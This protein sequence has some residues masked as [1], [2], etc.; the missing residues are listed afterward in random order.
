MIANAGAF[1]TKAVGFFLLV[2]SDY[3]RIEFFRI[4]RSGNRRA[5]LEISVNAISIRIKAGVFV[6]LVRLRFTPLRHII[7]H[8][9]E[10]AVC[11]RRTAISRS[12]N[13]SV[14]GGY[15]SIQRNN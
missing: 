13:K 4:L 6:A 9:T 15:R 11:R 12:V 2:P 7:P 8:I 1:R 5:T 3:L 10:R 14:L